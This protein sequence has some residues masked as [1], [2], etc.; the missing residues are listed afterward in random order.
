MLSMFTNTLFPVGQ[1]P[2]F[3]VA[4]ENMTVTTGTSQQMTVTATGNPLPTLQF[5]RVV[6]GKFL[7]S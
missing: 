7:S 4:L 1:P 2:E 6:Q 5:F 3:T